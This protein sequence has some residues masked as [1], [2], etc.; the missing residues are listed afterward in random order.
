ME[1]INR[2]YSLTSCNFACSLFFME[3]R[4]S[5]KNYLGIGGSYGVLSLILASSPVA[6]KSV[7]ELKKFP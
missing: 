1:G 3:M 7:A 5:L 2:L 6:L 4:E